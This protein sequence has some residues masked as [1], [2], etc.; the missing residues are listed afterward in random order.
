MII[1]ATGMQKPSGTIH[2]LVDLRRDPI[3]TEVRNMIAGCEGCVVAASGGMDSLALMMAAVL[4]LKGAEQV[5][6]VHVDHGL[7][8]NA[9][10]DSMMCRI[11]ATS[12]GCEFVE[13]KIWIPRD[14]NIY[15]SARHARYAAIASCAGGCRVLTAHHADDLAE[16]IIMRLARGS[17]MQSS[18]FIGSEVK[19]FGCTVQRP[20]LSFSK[21]ELGDFVRR[22]GM[23]W[24]D[25]E[26]NFNL[27]RE[28]ARLR[29]GVMKSLEEMYPGFS[30]AAAKSILS[31]PEADSH[32][33][34]APRSP[35]SHRKSG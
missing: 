14:G 2:D 27:K 1:A 8:P 6:I 26:S 21:K 5:K 7:R 10:R 13:K 11:Q 18:I 35:L 30:V 22:S 31:R 23:P 32:R 19:I 34:Q 17:P 3:V 29:A 24:V 12:I 20:L 28:R 4:A 25:D 33:D 9:W 15:E 16:T